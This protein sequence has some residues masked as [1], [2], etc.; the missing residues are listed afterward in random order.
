MLQGIF[1]HIWLNMDAEEQLYCAESSFLMSSFI[2][3]LT[4]DNKSGTDSDSLQNIVIRD[5]THKDH[6]NILD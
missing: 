3:I 5:L 1:T 6:G 2:S 4:G